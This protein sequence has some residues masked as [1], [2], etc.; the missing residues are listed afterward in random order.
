[1]IKPSVGQARIMRAA[2]VADLMRVP[3]SMARSSLTRQQLTYGS[4]PWMTYDGPDREWLVLTRAGAAALGAGELNSYDTRLRLPGAGRTGPMTCR[5][6]AE[7]L[8]THGDRPVEVN[9]II[10]MGPGSYIEQRS[11]A[12]LHLELNVD[13]S[14]GHEVVSV[15]VYHRTDPR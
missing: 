2:L 3:A 1:M 6:L 13:P 15:A 4:N 12:E 11:N 9:F 7:Q 14:T 5:E 8:I 10:A